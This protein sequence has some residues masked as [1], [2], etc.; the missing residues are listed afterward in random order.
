MTG[1]TIQKEPTN[2]GMN[3]VI[4]ESGEDQSTPFV[5]IWWID[6]FSPVCHNM[7]PPQM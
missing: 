7:T 4:S 1:N 3:A 6:G 2:I 5:K